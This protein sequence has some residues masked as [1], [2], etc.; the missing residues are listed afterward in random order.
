[1]SQGHHFGTR[2]I[3]DLH[4]CDEHEDK[5]PEPPKH[6]NGHE[7]CFCENVAALRP[8]TF[9][10]KN[11]VLFVPP[12]VSVFVVL[13]LFILVFF[14]VLFSLFSFVLRSLARLLQAPT[15]MV[16]DIVEGFK[17]EGGPNMAQTLVLWPRNRTVALQ[18]FQ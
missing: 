6:L 12:P 16:L 11:T 5:E 3:R 1:M 17:S 4:N 13:F 14:C 8:A 7:P 9:S 15:S 2:T 18:I 10:Q